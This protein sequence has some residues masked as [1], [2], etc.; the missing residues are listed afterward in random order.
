[1]LKFCFMNNR[2]AHHLDGKT[3]SYSPVKCTGNFPTGFSAEGSRMRLEV[4]RFHQYPI[5][6]CCHMTHGSR[7]AV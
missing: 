6:F 1:M 7:E 4:E 2:H 5:T 3:Y